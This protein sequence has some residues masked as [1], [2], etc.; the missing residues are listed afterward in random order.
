MPSPLLDC[1]DATA[2]SL[3]A[4]GVTRG[5]LCR[6]YSSCTGVSPVQNNIHSQQQQQQRERVRTQTCILTFM[7][8]NTYSGLRRDSKFTAHLCYHVCGWT[9][10][11]GSTLGSTQ[12]RTNLY[13]VPSYASVLAHDPIS[14][15]RIH[16]GSNT[17]PFNAVYHHSVVFI[18]SQ[19]T[20]K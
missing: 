10:C 9:R 5:L 19:N 3:K 16:N 8:Y 7:N 11:Q 13:H 2:A 12:S 20:D 15:R 18:S 14:G 6:L 17:Q 4:G 1:N